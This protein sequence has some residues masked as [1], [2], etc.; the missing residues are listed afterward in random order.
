[1]MSEDLFKKAKN[2]LP[3]GVDSPVRAFKPYPFF[4]E[5]AEGPFIYD[6]DGNDYLDYCLAYGPM[7]LGHANQHVV[8][9][10]QKQLLMGSVYGT[11]TEGEIDLAKEV[12]QRIP[13]AEMVRFVN[14]GTEAT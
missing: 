2:Y 3:G 12:I 10:V 4:A 5:K 13:C 9:S 1:M 11:P 6:V 14:S 8:E 7:V